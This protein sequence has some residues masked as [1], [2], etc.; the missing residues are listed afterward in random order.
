MNVLDTPFADRPISSYNVV[1]YDPASRQ[2]TSLQIRAVDSV[3]AHERILSTFGPVQ[4]LEMV[5]V[6]GTRVNCISPMEGVVAA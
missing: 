3:R 6:R 2:F 1:F 4:V 5:Q